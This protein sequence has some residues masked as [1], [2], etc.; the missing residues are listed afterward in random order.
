MF[1]LSVSE[2]FYEKTYCLHIR[3]RY[4]SGDAAKLK[5]IKN[6]S[7]MCSSVVRSVG[8]NFQQN[9]TISTILM[10]KSAETAICGGLAEFWRLLVF[11]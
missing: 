3:C 5:K 11:Q 10:E 9:R 1:K 6:K 7:M 4:G 2:K 8:F